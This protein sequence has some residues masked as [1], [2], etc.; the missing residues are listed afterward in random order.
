MDAIRNWASSPGRSP[1]SRLFSLSMNPSMTHQDI[2]TSSDSDM[3]VG[4]ADHRNNLAGPRRSTATLMRIGRL[5]AK[6]PVSRWAVGRHPPIRQDSTAGSTG[7]VPSGERP[8]R[9]RSGPYPALRRFRCS[10]SFAAICRGWCSAPT[11]FGSE[12]LHVAYCCPSSVGRP[13]NCP[14]PRLR[15][16]L[17]FLHMLFSQPFDTESSSND[18]V[19]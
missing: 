16:V 15:H 19:E 3:A 5:P 13:Y 8:L 7:Q 12:A 17:N 2:T 10:R 9:S 1:A 6:C 4:F 18:L 11:T 14:D